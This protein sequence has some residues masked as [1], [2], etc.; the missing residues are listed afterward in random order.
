VLGPR[1]TRFG[2]L[3]TLYGIV[4]A[5]F[6]VRPRGAAR[7]IS[8]AFDRPLETALGRAFAAAAVGHPGQGAFV[9]LEDGAK[10]FLARAALVR[11]AERAVDVQYYIYQGDSAGSV[12]AYELLRAAERGVRVRILLDDSGIG[13]R[14][15][16]LAELD[17]HRN[18]EVR[19]FNPTVERAGVARVV[20]FLTRISRLNRRMHNKIMTVDGVAAIVGGRNIGDHYFGAPTRLSFRDYDVLMGGAAA[21]QAGDSFDGFWSSDHAFP[22]GALDDEVPEARAVQLLARL[23]RSILRAIPDYEARARGAAATLAEWAGPDGVHW[24]VGRVVSEPPER[25]SGDAATGVVVGTLAEALA[26]AEREVLIESSYFVPQDAGVELLAGLVRRGVAVT[27]LTNALASTDVPAVHAGYAPYRHALLEAGVR[28]H[29]FRRR[30]RGRRRWALRRSSAEHE[31]SLHAKV[32]V[33]DR[34]WSWIGSFN[35]DPRSTRLNTEVGVMIE[36]PS[37]AAELADQIAADI[38][39]GHAWRVVLEPDAFGVPGLVWSG[40]R[41]G[42]PV[43]VERE[44]DVGVW[45]RLQQT[46]YGLMP[47]IET[48][49]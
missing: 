23:E 36:S 39:P 17:A 43:R 2:L 13:L 20:E 14:D 28:L 45:R 15:V 30:P 3:R 44:P 26:S 8:T 46:A 27:V 11:R 7:P 10:A 18:V 35:M 24:A 16:V 33:I 48:V 5:L 6:G 40:E 9:L 42:R 21:A 49:L 32:M 12:L 29:E 34:R 19:V 25:I 38:A 1:R 4:R 22:I 31:T 41:D 47:G 37:F